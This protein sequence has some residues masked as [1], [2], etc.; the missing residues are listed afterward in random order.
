[1]G[2]TNGEQRRFVDKLAQVCARHSRCTA[3][4]RRDV[5]VVGDRLVAKVHLENALTAAKIRRVDDDLSVETAWTQQRR[6]EYVGTVGGGDEITPS[7][8]SKPSI[9]T[10]SWLSVCSRSS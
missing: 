3:R 5:D 4:Q 6:I 8:D 7:F 2:A 9:S 1:V 10:S